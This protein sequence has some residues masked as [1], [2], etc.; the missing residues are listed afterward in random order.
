MAFITGPK[1]HAYTSWYYLVSLSV[2]NL[3]IGWGVPDPGL[4]L[5]HSSGH[6]DIC[7]KA[8]YQI[9]W[10]C[11]LSPEYRAWIKVEFS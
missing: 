11:W 2:G 4:V 6:P 9:H 8:D 5:S 10:S 1:K 3:G 7:T